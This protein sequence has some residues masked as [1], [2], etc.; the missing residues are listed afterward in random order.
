[1]ERWICSAA[2]G[3]IKD[4]REAIKDLPDDMCLSAAGGD[5]YVLVN[6]S[7]NTVVLDEKDWSDSWNELS[8]NK[9]KGMTVKEF[10]LGTPENYIVSISQDTNDN[11]VF[12]G[13]YAELKENRSD[14][15]SEIVTSWDATPMA[16]D[17]D[18]IGIMI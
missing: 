2:C 18:V 12:N 1:M 17:I 8:A 4:L 7:E 16:D 5:C 15:L 11:E 3:T 10:L 14:L 6:R 9:K 13:T